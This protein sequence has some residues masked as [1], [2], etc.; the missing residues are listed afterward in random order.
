M[1]LVNCTQALS[2]EPLTSR[3]DINEVVSRVGNGQVV[4]ITPPKAP[5]AVVSEAQTLCGACSLASA[6]I[7]AVDYSKAKVGP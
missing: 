3:A 1:I 7:S 2:L 6:R 4:R 5:A